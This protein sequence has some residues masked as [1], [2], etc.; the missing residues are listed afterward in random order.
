MATKPA[1]RYR[2]SRTGLRGIVAQ[3]IKRHRARASWVLRAAFDRV[4]SDRAMV[5][6]Q[7]AALT[8][9]TGILKDYD[10][11]DWETPEKTSAWVRQ[12]REIDGRATDRKLSS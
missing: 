10:F 9:S 2:R 6:R 12:Q 3:L 7:K 11:P 5:E 1:R 8:R 4:E